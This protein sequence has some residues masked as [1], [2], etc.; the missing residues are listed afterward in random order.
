VAGFLSTLDSI[1]SPLQAINS[2]FI[3][4]RWKRVISSAPG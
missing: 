4:R 2:A 1:C 3:Y